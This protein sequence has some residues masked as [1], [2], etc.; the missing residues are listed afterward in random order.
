MQI[1]GVKVIE[2][3]KELSS[4][5]ILFIVAGI[6][7]IIIGIILIV[8]GL[9]DNSKATIVSGILALATAIGCL[10]AVS[11][12]PMDI[13]YEILIDKEEA[14][15]ELEDNYEIIEKREYTYIV[16]EKDEEEKKLKFTID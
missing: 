6:G 9:G 8:N 16:K 3:I 14:I 4:S 11:V 7:L 5:S 15:E 13:T 12:S 2:T 1:D 10:A